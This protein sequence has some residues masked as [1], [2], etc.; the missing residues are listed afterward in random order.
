[1][2]STIFLASENSIIV[3]SLK[4]SV[5]LDAGVAGAH[6]ALDEQHRLARSTSS[7]GMPY[8]GLLGSVLAAGL[9]TSLAPMTKATSAW[10][11]CAVDVL[12]LEHLV[13]RHVRLGQQHV[14]VPGMRPATG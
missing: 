2:F 3:L 5:V 10:A 13:V 14:H 12:E 9:V 11:N 7:T 8:I 1:M 4:N 6:A